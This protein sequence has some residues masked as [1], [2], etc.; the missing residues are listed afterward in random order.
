M[1]ANDV[2]VDQ[3]HRQIIQKLKEIMKEGKPTEGIMFKKVDK[4]MLRNAAEKVNLAIKFIDTSNITQTNDLIRAAS[5][6]V[7]E[8]LGLKRITWREK[9]EP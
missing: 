3:D 5:V 6:W 9:N 8:E 1:E 7:T 4:K 2:E